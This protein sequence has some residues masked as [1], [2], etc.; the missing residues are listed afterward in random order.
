MSDKLLMMLAIDLFL[1]ELDDNYEGYPKETIQ[2]IESKVYESYGL[3]L[4]SSSEDAL[5]VKNSMMKDVYKFRDKLVK[6]I[7]E[8]Q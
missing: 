4:S 8:N 1:V 6:E 3:E 2:L 7:T 5:H